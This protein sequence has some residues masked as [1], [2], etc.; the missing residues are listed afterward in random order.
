MS[1]KIYIGIDPSFTCTGIVC[2]DGTNVTPVAFKSPKL[3]HDNIGEAI[4]LTIARDTIRYEISKFFPRHPEPT[5][6]GGGDE[7]MIGVE[8]PMGSHM[9]SGAKVDRLFGVIVVLLSDMDCSAKIFTPG[10]I[11]K[12]VTGKGNA[13]KELMMKEVYKRWGFETDS[14]D[15][16]DAYAIAR[17]VEAIDKKEYEL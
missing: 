7:I 16:A 13:K 11:K 12:F 4:R 5:Q 2:F 15:I 8:M 3:K 6:T 1:N 14:H 10:Q 17:L 9:G